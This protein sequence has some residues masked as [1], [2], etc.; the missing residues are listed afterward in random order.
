[1]APALALGVLAPYMVAAKQEYRLLLPLG[2]SES[3]GTSPPSP[4]ECANT[5]N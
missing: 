3:A 2:D 4:A 5:L 1:V